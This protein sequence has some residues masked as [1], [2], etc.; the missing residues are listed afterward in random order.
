MIQE[1]KLSNAVMVG[2]VSRDACNRQNYN[3]VV[4]CCMLFLCLCT[5]LCIPVQIYVKSLKKF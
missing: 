4:S 1:N 2:F 3:R 5:Y